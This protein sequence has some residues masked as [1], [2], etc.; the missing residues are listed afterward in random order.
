M[1]VVYIRVFAVCMY[2][3]NRYSP[4]CQENG[5]A[6]GDLVNG[7]S[8]NPNNIARCLPYYHEVTLCVCGKI[9]Y[10]GCARVSNCQG[11]I[12]TTERVQNINFNYYN[13]RISLSFFSHIK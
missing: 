12:L 1:R 8:N 6:K 13:H 11:E 9:R 5:E 2:M 3:Q 7:V 4:E 10:K